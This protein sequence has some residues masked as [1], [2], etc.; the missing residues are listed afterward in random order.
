MGQQ[1]RAGQG[2][3]PP[4]AGGGGTR[5]G[6]VWPPASP[7]LQLPGA[8]QNPTVHSLL[9]ITW[10]I[11]QASKERGVEGCTVQ[12]GEARGVIAAVQLVKSGW[13]SQGRGDAAQC[14]QRGR[15]WGRGRRQTGVQGSRQGG[16]VL[17][18]TSAGAHQ[19]GPACLATAVGVEAPGGAPR[20]W[21][22]IHNTAAAAGLGWF[23]GSLRE[24]M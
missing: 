20:G 5:G 14:R 10:D 18:C 1:Q 13:R 8:C 17:A 9:R 3:L 19:G 23:R 24:V 12:R 2:K 4:A 16:R 11:A 6:A 15:A 21:R 22:P 7:A